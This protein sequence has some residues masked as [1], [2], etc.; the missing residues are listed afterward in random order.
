MKSKRCFFIGHR[1]AP[2]NIYTDIIT[3]IEKL[4][5]ENNVKEFIVGNYGNFDRMVISALQYLKPRYPHIKLTLLTSYHPTVKNIIKPEGFDDIYYPEGMELVPYKA[6]IIRANEKAIDSSDYLI[7]YVTHPASNT[8]KFVE[9]AEKRKS[10]NII[11]QF[12]NYKHIK[13]WEVY[14]LWRYKQVE[15]NYAM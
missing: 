2:Q 4:I 14:K 3:T 5:V 9:Y 11:Y 8:A 13:Y 12:V 15:N 10:I 6:A 1:N 7:A